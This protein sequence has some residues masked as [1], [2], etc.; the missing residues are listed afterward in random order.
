M[1]ASAIISGLGTVASGIMSAINNKKAQRAADA[2]SARQQA[3]YEAKAAENPLTRSE[4]AAV[5]NEYDRAAKEQMETARNVGK[6]T[7]ATTEQAIATQQAVADGRASLM[8]GIA[9]QASTNREKNLDAAERA[10]QTKVANDLA[11][12]ESRN[13]TYAALAANAA[14]A[15]GGLYTDDGT[16][17]KVE[18]GSPTAKTDQRGAQAK[19]DEEKAK[20][21]VGKD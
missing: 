10:R 5:I 3:H 6:I 13:T 1:I 14:S 11:R 8:S 16:D 20:T 17:A 4:N 19:A 21:G 2:E 15:L 7:G 12:L 18:G 9:S